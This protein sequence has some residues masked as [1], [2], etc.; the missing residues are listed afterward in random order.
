MV[1]STAAPS[2][3]ALLRNESRQSTSRGPLPRPRAHV[4]AVKYCPGIIYFQISPDRFL[5]TS[6]PAVSF[7]P[8]AFDH[9]MTDA[10][11]TCSAPT[12]RLLLLL[13]FYSANG[14]GHRYAHTHTTICY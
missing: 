14:I 8:F 10:R 2:Q 9:D 3:C 7:F 6:L 11:Y 4:N 5:M 13:L 12:N 1:V